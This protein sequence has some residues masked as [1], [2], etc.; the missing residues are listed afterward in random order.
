MEHNNV[1]IVTRDNN[2]RKCVI[3]WLILFRASEILWAGL[4]VILNFIV[5]I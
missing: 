4:G 5:I 2:M 1:I 3:D